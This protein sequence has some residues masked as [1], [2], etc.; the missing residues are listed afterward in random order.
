MFDIFS[1]NSYNIEEVRF[2]RFY[3]TVF[4]AK[5]LIHSEKDE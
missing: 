4:P 3:F 2:H 1:Y 5:L